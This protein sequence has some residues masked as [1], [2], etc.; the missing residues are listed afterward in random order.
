MDL[1]TRNNILTVVLGILIIGLSYFLYKSI[2]DPYQEV[3]EERE[4]V[5]RERHRMELVRDA[6]VQYRNRRG[7][8]PP[9]DGG[10]DSL[11]QFVKTNEFIVERADS[12]F[13]FMPPSSYNPDSLVYSPRAPYNRFEYTL[14]DTIRPQ[15]YLLE[16]P[17][18]GD[19]IGDLQR[20]TLLNAPNWN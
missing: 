13:A 2:V 15:L 6:L 19:K 17:G 3:I 4:M 7:D 5:E 9:T 12:L 10:L 18:T 11:V 20:T 1:Y 16:N 14:N 8:F